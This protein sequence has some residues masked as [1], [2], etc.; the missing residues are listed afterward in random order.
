MTG[1]T[2]NQALLRAAVALQ[3]EGLPPE[4]PV[5]IV[6]DIYGRLRFAVDAWRPL[7]QGEQP[8]GPR[9]E[10]RPED[11]YPAD[12]LQRLIEAAATLGSYASVPAVLFKDDFSNPASLFEHRDWHQTI[13]TVPATTAADGSEVP[14]REIAVRLLDRQVVGQDWLRTNRFAEQGHPPRV[15]FYGL[16]G[17]VGRS[18]ALAMF[19][20]RLARDGKKVLLIDFDLESPGLSGL[21]LP[22]E[23][24]ASCGLV[25]WFVEDSVGQGDVVLRDMISVS[26]LADNTQGS[27]RVAAA[28]GQGETAYLSKLARVYVDVPSRNGPQTFAD[29]MLKITGLLEAQEQPHIV[30]IDSRAGLHDVAAVAIGS[31]ASVALLFATDSPQ[32]WQ[33]YR[34]LFMHWQQ[35]PEVLRQVR[36]RIV[37]VQALFPESD[38]ADRAS[39][40][41]QNAWDVFHELVYDQL[42]PGVEAPVDA[43]TFDLHS[44]D[45]P[46]FPMRVRWN[47]RFQEF[48]P[49]LSRSAGGVDDTDIDLAFGPFVQ[50]VID[51][52]PELTNG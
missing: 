18:T 3:D 48:N 49:L 32:N 27:I 28:M 36:D 34:Q 51:A 46:H 45:A 41:V 10:A 20:Y 40:F 19:A 25:D 6:R 7:P 30:L 9:A 1:C 39:R 52:L 31:M 11:V 29:R 26:P 5:G 23:R 8:E 44:E 43:F 37:M 24:V 22:P 35:R 4:W 17:G 50:E 47:A 12:A 15:V 2:F 42:E 14:G 16:K 33:G 13:V 38:Q 21:L